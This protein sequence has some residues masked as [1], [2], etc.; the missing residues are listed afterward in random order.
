[1]SER[2]EALVRRF[3]RAYQEFLSVVEPL[4][5]DQWQTFCPEDQCTVAALTRHVAAALPFQVKMFTAI[6]AGQ[7]TEPLTWAWLAESNAEDANTYAACNHA[8]T[9]LL[10]NQNAA[11]AATFIRALNADQL[12]QTGNY[13]EGVPALTVDQ[14]VRHILIGHIT[15]HLAS[16]RAA[17][18]IST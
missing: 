9:I 12:T 7:P 4:T 5:S 18:E 16:I 10:L 3:E 8:E 15:T 11:N 17:L 14:W 2:A 13:I 6:A 1:V